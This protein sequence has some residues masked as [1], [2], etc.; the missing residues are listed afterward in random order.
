MQVI[1]DIENKAQGIVSD[2]DEIK[3]KFEKDLE[4]D[5]KKIQTEYENSAEAKIAKIRK[6]IAEN[7][8]KQ[9]R[10]IDNMHRVQTEKLVECFAEN[11]D[12][13]VSEIT[14][15]ILTEGF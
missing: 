11:Q 3:K 15:S 8:E 12:K 5:K 10:S 1:L 2:A 9:I 14:S 13:W 6:S 7:E 4:L